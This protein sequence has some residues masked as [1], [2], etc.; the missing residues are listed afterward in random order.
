[1]KTIARQKNLGYA[2]VL[3]VIMA[4]RNH[5]KTARSHKKGLAL[6]QSF[7]VVKKK[8]IEQRYLYFFGV[9]M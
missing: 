5:E 4:L 1:L 2:K 3:L 8:P 9:C 7:L 6:D